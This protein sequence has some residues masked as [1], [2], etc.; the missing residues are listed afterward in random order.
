MQ[1]HNLAIMFGPTLFNSGDEKTPKKK[2]TSKKKKDQKKDETPTVQ[3]N[4]HLAFNMIM[5][6]QIV[7]YLLTEQSKFEALQGPIQTHPH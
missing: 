5:Q 4:S 2:E 7:E 6:G 1:T 3:S